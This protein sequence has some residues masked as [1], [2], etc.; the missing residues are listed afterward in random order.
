VNTVTAGFNTIMGQITEMSLGKN[1]WVLSSEVLI[2]LMG[3]AGI[4]IFFK[5]LGV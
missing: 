3:I 4:N 5:C 1:S 2:L